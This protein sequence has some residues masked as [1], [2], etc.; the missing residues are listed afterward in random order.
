MPKGETAMQYN[1]PHILVIKDIIPTAKNRELRAAMDSEHPFYAHREAC[2]QE[3]LGV[4]KKKALERY[5]QQ[6]LNICEKSLV[7]AETIHAEDELFSN[8]RLLMCKDIL[9]TDSESYALDYSNTTL[10]AKS[11]MGGPLKVFTEVDHELRPIVAPRRAIDACTYQGKTY[12]LDKE[13][14]I[15]P[16]IKTLHNTAPIS[17]PLIDA[18]LNTFGPILQ[19]R[20]SNDMLCILRERTLV[21]FDKDHKEHVIALNDHEDDFS[22]I[23]RITQDYIYVKTMDNALHIYSMGEKKERI[24]ELSDRNPEHTDSILMHSE[25]LV[26][27]ERKKDAVYVILKDQISNGEEEILIEAHENDEL[28]YIHPLTKKHI[29]IHTAEAAYVY[30]IFEK[31]TPL[32]VRKEGQ[33]INDVIPGSNGEFW[34]VLDTGIIEKWGTSPSHDIMNIY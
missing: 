19:M 17:H 15:L 27:L 29:L 32:C 8:H 7:F 16:P 9:D 4:L 12:F 21:L 23:A 6:L 20:S 24:A 10:H 34:T 25:S 3:E 5:N 26:S 18:H 28:L 13:G 14:K 33:T 22:H 31:T 2:E 30:N 11:R 1:D